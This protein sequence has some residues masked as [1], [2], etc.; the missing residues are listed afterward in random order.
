MGFFD[1]FKR[2]KSKLWQMPERADNLLVT[3]ISHSLARITLGDKLIVK[4]DW[5]VVL[6]AKDRALDIF[7]E[8]EHTLNLGVMP[9]ITKLLKLDVGRKR[10]HRGNIIVELPKDFLCDIYFVNLKMFENRIW[11]TES[12]KFKRQKEVVKFWMQGRFDF[13]VKNAHDVIELFLIDWGFIRSD[14]A[15]G[16]IDFLVSEFLTEEISKVKGLMPD[17]IAKQEM[18]EKLFKERIDKKFEKYGLRF[19]NVGVESVVYPRNI[20]VAPIPIETEEDKFENE[21]KEEKSDS[22]VTI[23]EMPDEEADKSEEQLVLANGELE[24]NAEDNQKGESK[25]SKKGSIFEIEADKPKLSG[26]RKQSIKTCPK[27]GE[28]LKVKSTKCEKCGY[29]TE[30]V[31]NDSDK[32]ICPDCGAENDSGTIF[33]KCGCY[34]PPKEL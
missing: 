15:L 17:E 19:F 5:M 4:R 34:L 27:C 24:K 23:G 30:V 31:E 16:K 26:R 6:V 33:C 13:Q 28:I 29:D 21:P 10:K 25:K 11:K 18:F 2:K 12:I 14:M 32:I 1:W 7:S 9:H 20:E 22:V 3:A 8:G